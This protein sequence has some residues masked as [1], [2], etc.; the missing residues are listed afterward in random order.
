[1]LKRILV[2]VDDE[3]G[4]RDAAALASALAA[5]DD[6]DVLLA[7]VY[8]D[9]LLPFPLSLGRDGPGL[10]QRARAVPD[11]SPARA[12]RHLA[13]R[14]HADLLV[15]GSSHRVP[16]GRARGG[17]TARQILHDAP[18]AVAIAV[19]GL[20]GAGVPASLARVV[21]GYDGSPESRAALALAA[22]LGDGTG[23]Q[24]EAVS[25]ADDTLPALAAPVGA[26]GVLTQ[27]DEV[28]E[29]KRQRAQRLAHEAQ[30]ACAAC[31]GATGTLRV[32][33]PAAELAEVAA[34]ADLLVL[35]SRRWGRLERI[36]LGS[37]GEELLHEAPCSLLFVPRPAE[38]DAPAADDRA[39]AAAGDDD[40]DGHAAAPA[41][42]TRDA[43]V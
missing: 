26:V 11:V 14:E 8:P 36:A 1:M 27:W 42:A 4:S 5:H 24:L 19:R 25:V 13:A 23:A 43:A 28:V 17:R 20:A 39:V 18:C 3:P 31:D 9:P 22:E 38:A 37:T 29:L 6:A 10:G 40:A 7:A 16:D 41:A 32:G 12:L 15:L 21:A 34:D 33:D 35:G 2:G 30:D